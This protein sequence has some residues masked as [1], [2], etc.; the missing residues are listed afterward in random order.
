MPKE[1]AHLECYL[2]RCYFVL[3]FKHLYKCLRSF[4]NKAKKTSINRLDTEG[5]LPVIIKTTP[6]NEG[7]CSLF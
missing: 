2:E 7:V 6:K 3:I 4:V 1:V 5:L